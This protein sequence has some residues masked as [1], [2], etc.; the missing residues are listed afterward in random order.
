[1]KKL[2]A[3][4]TAFVFLGTSV[5]VA[6]QPVVLLNSD[7]T[8]AKG[9][10]LVDGTVSFAIRAAFTKAGQ[11]KAGASTG[12]FKRIVSSAGSGP[13]LAKAKFMVESQPLE[14][15]AMTEQVIAGD[16]RN[17]MAHD[18]FTRAAMAAELMVGTGRDRK[19]VV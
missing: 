19:S 7:T 3:L 17:T 14:A 10:L 16:P 5:A 4:V 9:P 15:L 1:M 8:A 2:L 13:T 6:H 18:L 12:L 11:K